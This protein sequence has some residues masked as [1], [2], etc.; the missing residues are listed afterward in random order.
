[1]VWFVVGMFLL[2]A[3]GGFVIGRRDR[4]RSGTG[5]F[6]KSARNRARVWP[7]LGGKN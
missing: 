2:G 7:E 6:P 1:M 3:L 5:G 4:Y